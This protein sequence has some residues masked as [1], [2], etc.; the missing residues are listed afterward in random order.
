MFV[1]SVAL[2][3]NTEERGATLVEL[4][5]GVVTFA[6]IGGSIVASLLQISLTDRAVADRAQ[7]SPAG[8]ALTVWVQSDVASSD[9]VINDSIDSSG[10]NSTAANAWGCAGA[11]P[12][13]TTVL[14]IRQVGYFGAT[15]VTRFVIYRSEPVPGALSD[16]ALVRRVC[17]KGG[18]VSDNV[19]IVR[20]MNTHGSGLFPGVGASAT[21][22]PAADP[23]LVARVRL[24]VEAVGSNVNASGRPESTS[25]FVVT[26]SPRVPVG[27]VADNGGDSGG[28]G[29]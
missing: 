12:T 4:V 7:I 20:R 19:T 5:I 24:S 28:V 23:A 15:S 22:A 3:V 14:R 18:P 13:G 25:N 11:S 1:R 6:I 26:A 27:I 2:P 9:A 17:T 16:R 8:D 21:L 10:A 29:V